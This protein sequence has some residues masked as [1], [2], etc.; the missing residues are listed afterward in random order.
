MRKLLHHELLE[1]RKSP[2]EALNTERHPIALVAMSIRSM[3]NVGSL[4][5]TSDSALAQ[6]LI[7]CGF[8]P[9]PPRD[10]IVKTALGAT[11]SV[12]WRYFKDSKE[13]IKTLKEEGYKI[14]ALELTN[15]SRNYSDINK[16]DFP[17]CIV[18]GNELSGLDDDILELCDFALE[19]PMYGVKHSLN[20]SVAAGISLFEAVKRYRELFK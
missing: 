3:Y 20:V 5:R 14:A 17:L 7:L 10:E 15:K 18:L 4:F 1:I 8:T 16:E 11:E 19:I 13:A 9:C 12:P 2:D 6:E